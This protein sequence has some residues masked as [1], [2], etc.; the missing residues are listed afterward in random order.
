MSISSS[1]L[2]SS[3]EGKLAFSLWGKALFSVSEFSG[4]E[5]HKLGKKLEEGTGILGKKCRVK[6]LW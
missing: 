5:T 4:E 1:N 3:L 6:K 2:C